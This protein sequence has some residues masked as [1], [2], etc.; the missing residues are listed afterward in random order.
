MRANWSAALL[1]LGAA[2]CSAAQVEFFSPQGEV[3]GVRQV[4]VR[5]S[6]PMVAFGDPSLPDPFDIV[7]P[8]PGT[9]R[10]A[11]QKNWVYDFAYDLPAGLRCSFHLKS[12]LVSLDGNNLEPAP[13]F[14][15]NTGGPAIVQM[16]PYEGGTSTKS[17][18]FCSGSTHRRP[19]RR[20]APT[21]IATSAVSASVSR[22][23]SLLERSAT[24]CWPD[25]AISWTGFF[26]CCSRTAANS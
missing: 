26:T 3:K 18:F 4:A 7:C 9:A 16:M 22:Y 10:W 20:S 12:D 6:G 2:V 5:F 24:S 17:R 21:P 15:F 25:V 23:A 13:A 8:V 11:D 1:M 19:S 14:E